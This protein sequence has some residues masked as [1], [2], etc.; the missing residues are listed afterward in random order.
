MERYRM[1]EK[2]EKQTIPRNETRPEISIRKSWPVI[3]DA[4]AV[5]FS[6]NLLVYHSVRVLNFQEVEIC[7][8][9]DI[10][11]QLYGVVG[12]GDDQL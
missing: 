1:E 3:L 11:V 8:A 9:W 5:M 2:A 7:L 12:R 10:N 4:A 6:L